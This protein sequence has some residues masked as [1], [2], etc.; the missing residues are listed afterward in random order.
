MV[1][2]KGQINSLENERENMQRDR[3]HERKRSQLKI[4]P[5]VLN[6]R[7][8]EIVGRKGEGK[9]QIEKK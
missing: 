5:R 2:V 6:I 4:N 1:S 9:K 3:N 8:M 7:R